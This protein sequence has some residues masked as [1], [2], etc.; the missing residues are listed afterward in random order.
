MPVSQPVPSEPI[1]IRIR[2]AHGLIEQILRLCGLE[3]YL[4]RPP[5]SSLLKQA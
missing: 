3:P 4:E 1:E 5:M 2:G